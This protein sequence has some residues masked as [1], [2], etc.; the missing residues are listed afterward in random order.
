M[1]AQSSPLAGS[2]LSKGHLGS[3][4]GR[5]GAATPIG[6]PD[7][8]RGN[9]N[10]IGS[11]DGLRG[12][13]FLM[14]F[15]RH[16]GLT[17]HTTQPWIKFLTKFTYAGWMG[18]DLF[19]ALS[20][21]LITSIL[22]DTREDRRYFTNFYMRRAL[23]IFPI[24][25]SIL[26]SLLLLTPLLHLQWHRGH[27]AYWIYMGNVAYNLNSG[28][29]FLQPDV[30]LVH[31]W[32]LAAEEQFYLAWPLAVMVLPSRRRL[33]YVCGWLSLGGL[34]LRLSLLATLPR[35]SAYEWCYFQ[36]PTHMDGLLYG[37]I[38]ANWIRSMPLE[39]VMRR[40]YRILPFALCMLAL[41]I[42]FNG[43]DFHSIA[44][45]TAGFPA[46]GAL[47][48]S[49]VLLA[50]KPGSRMHRFGNLKGLCFIGRYSYGMYLF[51]IL[52]LPGLAWLQPWL[53]KHLHSIVLGGMCFVLLMF[54]ATLGLAVLSYELYEKQWLRL[55]SRFAYEGHKKVTGEFA[56]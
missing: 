28:L 31:L 14:V 21:F 6:S 5:R 19:F 2:S 8:S 52:F 24:Y 30:S 39:N 44:M 1:R 7:G 53:Q 51:H 40:V 29:S 18:V 48:A 42:G 15:F 22:L 46:V 4:D 54:G 23:R 3:P 56:T 34:I 32:S 50:L 55:K 49:I 47:F 41:V 13:A 36:L 10:H 9:T 35:E 27:I 33:A 25:Y 45:V 11:L 43:F 16:Y 12:M 17:S 20:G 38:G 37:A 26:G